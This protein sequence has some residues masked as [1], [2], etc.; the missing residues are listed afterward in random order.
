MKRLLLQILSFLMPFI[1]LISLFDSLYS[2]SGGDLTRLGKISYPENYREQFIF[3]FQQQKAYT[4][5]SEIDLVAPHNFNVFAIGDSFSD[6]G[7][8][9]YQN[10]LSSYHDKTVLNFDFLNFYKYEDYNPVRFLKSI[11]N[12]SIL[13]RIKIKYIILE[14][15]ERIFISRQFQSE[16]HS[17]LSLTD[18][19]GMK[20]DIPKIDNNNKRKIS[21]YLN[22]VKRFYAYNLGY[23]FSNLPFDSKVYK[24][25]L[26]KSLFST[27][28][29]EILLYYQDITNLKDVN[30]DNIKH[31]NADLNEIAR[32]LKANDIQLIVMPCVDKYDLYYDYIVDNPYR[33]NLFFNYLSEEKREYLYVDTKALLRPYL[34]KGVKDLYFADDSHWSPKAAK[35]IASKINSLI[36]NN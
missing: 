8:I 33:K 20:R 36:R 7:V 27:H 10:Y 22:D 29:N 21:T 24:M 6:Q 30:K 2:K 16:P 31:L 4:D 35:I 3:D 1:I 17:N 14:V 11:M 12:D 34:K 28:D 23:W 32:K 26:S 15:A 5:F 25:K 18:L 19:V 9:G 13:S